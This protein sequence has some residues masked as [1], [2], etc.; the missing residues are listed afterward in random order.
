M[1][2]KYFYKKLKN[3][4][5]DTTS[6]PADYMYKFI[7]PTAST[8]VAEIEAIFDNLGAVITKKESAKGKYTSLTIALKVKSAQF[9]IEKYQ[10]VSKV[11]GVISL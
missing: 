2:S 4:L 7:V 9:V 3:S 6:F 11:A 1:N 5:E 10:E 8:G